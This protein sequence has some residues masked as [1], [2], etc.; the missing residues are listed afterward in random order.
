MSLI[1][2]ITAKLE[3]SLTT[4]KLQQRTRMTTRIHVLKVYTA[5][6]TFKKT[7][8]LYIIEDLFLMNL[9][10]KTDQLKLMDTVSSWTPDF[11]VKGRCEYKPFLVFD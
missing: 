9:S 7:F 3:V 10:R 4:K 1:S 2:W 11:S 6:W 5:M 8:E